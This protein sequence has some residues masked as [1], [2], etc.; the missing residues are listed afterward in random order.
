[1]EQT[2]EKRY[3]DVQIE[4]LERE[5]LVK[6]IKR[7]VLEIKPRL[8]VGGVRYTEAEKALETDDSTQVRD[9]LRNLERKGA[10]VA[11]FLDRV[12]TCPEC[13]SPEVF[14]KYACPKCKSINVEFTE[15]LEHMKCGYMG[16]KD[17]F[18]KDLSMV[19]PRCQTELVDDAL[20]YRRV[21]DCYKCEKC[22]HCFDTPEVIHICQQ[23]KRSFT[24]R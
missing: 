3:R 15:L 18:L 24:H 8:S 1:M 20:Q 17:D 22:G 4:D 23:C 13:G 16:S 10:L 6:L 19:C 11:Q 2:Q 21:G 7:G 9:V 5:L 12:L 14:S